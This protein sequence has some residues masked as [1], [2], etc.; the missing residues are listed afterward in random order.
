MAFDSLVHNT[1]THSEYRTEYCRVRLSLSHSHTPYHYLSLDPSVSHS[2]ALS[3]S[4]MFNPPSLST[5][6][7]LPP[8]LVKDYMY[9]RDWRK[10][11]SPSLVKKG[12]LAFPC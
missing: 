6:I 5:I 3:L 8:F 10:T 12:F 4:L 11:A 9:C 1:V 2:P 7:S